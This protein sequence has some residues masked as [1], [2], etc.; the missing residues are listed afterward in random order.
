ME[1]FSLFQGE[2]ELTGPGLG[3]TWAALT[4][5]DCCSY[6]QQWLTSRRTS[7]G[8]TVHQVTME[9]NQDTGPAWSPPVAIHKASVR[10]FVA[11]EPVPKL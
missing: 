1:T 3:L 10:V 8:G 9:Q 5:R 4:G 6:V 7:P 2:A 11:W